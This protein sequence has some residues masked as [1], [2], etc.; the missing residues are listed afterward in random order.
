MD[1]DRKIFYVPALCFIMLALVTTSSAAVLAGC[2]ST[3]PARIRVDDATI[4]RTVK[5]KLATDGETNSFSIDVITNE[6]VVTLQGRVKN[7]DAREKVERHARETDGVQ[8]VINLVK[9][10]DPQ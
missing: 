3:E 6:G 9:V 7:E 10:G 5:A 2:R 1:A 8:R 4:T